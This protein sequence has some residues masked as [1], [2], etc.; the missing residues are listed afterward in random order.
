VSPLS[1]VND[2]GR[3]R[4]L[5]GAVLGI[6]AD[7][8]LPHVLRNIV[9]A[10]VDVIGA[11]YG[12]LGV[13]SDRGDGLSEFV[14]VGIPAEEVGA[15]GQ[16]PQG[17]GI[18]GLLI[19]DPRP[20]R[21]AD[22]TRHPDSYGFPP[23]HPRM[24]SFIGVPILVRD[25]VFGNLYLTEKEH[26]AEFSLED[27][28]LAV[29]LAGAAGIAIENARLH[30]RVRD[31][32][33][34]E[35]RERIA[36]DLHDTVIQRLFATGLAL[37]GTVRAISPP[38]AAARVETAVGDLDETIRQIRSTIFALQAPRL[39]GRGLRAEILA[40]AAE[41]AASLRFEP[42]LHLVGPVDAAVDEEIGAQLLSVLREGLSNVVRHA[43]ATRVEVTVT[44][45]DARVRG[46]V[47]DDGVGP[48]TGSRAGGR[49]LANIAHRAE[50]LGGAMNLDAGPDGRGT[51]LV[52]Q[53][54]L[55]P[56][57]PAGAA[58]LDSTPSP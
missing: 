21:L 32:T 29:A 26:A 13:L 43:H 41:A 31:L 46:E 40:L 5:V 47:W 16:L 58:E 36:A 20:L 24:R 7:L 55:T 3:L 30:A 33:L 9:T 11:R 28:G 27:E 10:A 54:P 56:D 34:I 19:V 15:I 37:E 4:D 8:A 6:S 53:V 52:W 38:E 42:R 44:V 51:L 12:A 18:L 23:H 1:K 45:A 25:Q 57:S 39:P 35:D 48:G 49:G 14:H 50:A 17:N 2:P 22:L